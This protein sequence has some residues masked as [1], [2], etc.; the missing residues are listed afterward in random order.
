VFDRAD[1]LT[2]R[3]LKEGAIPDVHLSIGHTETELLVKS[4][5]V[6]PRTA[7]PFGTFRLALATHVSRRAVVTKIEDLAKPEVK[8]IVLT[9]PENSSVGA[10]AKTVL[11]GLGLWEKVSAKIVYLPTIKDCHTSLAAGKADAEFAYIGCPIPAEPD[12]AEY[13]KVVAVQ[14][15]HPELYGGATVF[16]SVLKAAPHRQEAVEFVTFLGT[17]EVVAMLAKVGLVPPGN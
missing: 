6:E 2:D 9:P 10:Y 4:G 12:K 7:V 8:A 15:V 11:S 5:H 16:A 17:P 13:S 3:I 14:I 1:L